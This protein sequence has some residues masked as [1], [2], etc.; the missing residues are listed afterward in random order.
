VR[1]RAA[2]QPRRPQ[3]RPRRAAPGFS[4][5]NRAL[6]TH[7][8]GPSARRVNRVRA[9]S[10]IESRLDMQPGR[11]PV[12][13]PASI[14]I[15]PSATSRDSSNDPHLPADH[16]QKLQHAFAAIRSRNGEIA[17][18]SRRSGAGDVVPGSASWFRAAPRREIVGLAHVDGL[19]ISRE[20]SLG[21]TDHKPGDN[22]S[23]EQPNG[24]SDEHGGVSVD[25]CRQRVS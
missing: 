18:A 9:A 14:T 7:I 22:R 3:G 4:S 10:R 15:W 12:L 11:R 17:S 6:Q 8:V 5:K 13:P 21:N 1:F 19:G 16:P 2:R 24:R 20:R 25:E 23:N